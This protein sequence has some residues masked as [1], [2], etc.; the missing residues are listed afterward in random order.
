RYLDSIDYDISLEPRLAQFRLDLRLVEGRLAAFLGRSASRATLIGGGRIALALYDVLLIAALMQAALAL[1]M[2]VYFHRATLLALP[3]NVVIVPLTGVL[4]PAA[5]LALVLSYVSPALAAI[6]AAI[7][8]WALHGITGTVEKLGALHAADVRVPDP[9]FA[10]A[11]AAAAALVL[12]MLTARRRPGLTIA[13]LAGL[14]AAAVALTLFP[15]QPQLRPGVL[16]VTLLDVGQ[17]DAI[18]VVSPQGRTLLIDAGG[19]LGGPASDFD[20][21]EDVVSPYLWSRGIGRL[22]AVALTHAHADHIGGLGSVLASFRPAELWLGQ[23]PPTPAF[24]S[25]LETAS[26]YGVRVAVHAE[27]DAF[28]FGGTRVEVLAPPRDWKLAV[29]PRNDDSLALRMTVG[30]TSALLAGD[31][32]R[33]IERRL[34]EHQPESELL[35]VAHH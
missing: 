26:T 22:D 21:G 13:G 17:G 14:V 3:A 8:E 20:M 30:E 5:L 27:G 7:A 16:E 15:P 2:A 33:R 29:R 32:E 18:L 4:M 35:K 6:P 28:D 19:S 34:A 1:P 31:V 12:A 9:A 23:N 25:L 10:I 11:A 24:R